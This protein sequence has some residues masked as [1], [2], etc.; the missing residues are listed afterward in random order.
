MVRRN[1]QKGR[2]G[3]LPHLP[4][5]TLLIHE[6]QHDLRSSVVAPDSSKHRARGV[7][8]VTM[9]V[10]DPPARPDE[11]EHGVGSRL[12]RW[13]VDRRIRRFVEDGGAD[14]LR[15]AGVDGL[16]RYRLH[17][18]CPAVTPP[19]ANGHTPAHTDP[20]PVAIG[21]VLHLQGRQKGER[22]GAVGQ[23]VC[24][25]PAVLSAQ[26]DVEQ[27]HDA[28]ARARAALDERDHAAAWEAAS[29]AAATAAIS[30][31]GFADPFDDVD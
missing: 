16:H 22:D 12:P 10:A 14:H 23:N 31:L 9:S 21:E 4:L 25:R 19:H 15:G 24:D 30:D 11:H 29:A 17:W 18:P 8:W 28:H 1:H 13:V 3:D 6:R 5:D 2:V 20:V 26:I 27:A 7:I